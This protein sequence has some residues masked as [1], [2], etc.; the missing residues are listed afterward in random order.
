MEILSVEEGNGQ[1]QESLS[2]EIQNGS[3]NFG[4]PFLNETKN[5]YTLC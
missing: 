2:M 4:K 5:K 3:S 1:Q